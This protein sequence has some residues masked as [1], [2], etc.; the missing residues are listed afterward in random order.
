MSL[1][2]GIHRSA[3]AIA[4][5]SCELFALSRDDFLTFL[6]NNEH[7]IQSVLASLSMR[8]RK[9]DDH[10][11]DTCFLNISARFAKKPLELSEAYGQIDGNTLLIEI[12]LTQSD[13]A[14]MIGTTRGVL[15]RS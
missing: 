3:E 5:E 12:D 11:E 10:L 15:I 13:L 1:L 7:A 2:D 6:M 4:L 9:T 8:L 14:G